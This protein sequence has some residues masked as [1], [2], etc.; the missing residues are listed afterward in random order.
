MTSEE[1]KITKTAL[2]AIM[3]SVRFATDSPETVTL[4]NS[5]IE[6]QTILL[7]ACF[8]G[9]AAGSTKKII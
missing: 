8:D 9:K 4:I 6:L 1:R 7:D 3:E 2:A 5:A